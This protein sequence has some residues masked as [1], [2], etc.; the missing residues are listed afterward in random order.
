MKEPVVYQAVLHQREARGKAEK[1]RALILR[2]G[3]KRFVAPDALVQAAIGAME[4]L[5][6]LERLA[7]RLL[8]AENWLEL[9]R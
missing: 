7:D 5:Q 4:S 9:L 6:A 3:S 2:I 1:A 8:E